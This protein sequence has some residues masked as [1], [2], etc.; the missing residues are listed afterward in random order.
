MER[1]KDS[2]VPQMRTQVFGIQNT[3]F[4]E[5]PALRQPQGQGR[6]LSSL[7]TFS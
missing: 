2:S 3:L 7:L 4:P 5:M 1:E 6:S